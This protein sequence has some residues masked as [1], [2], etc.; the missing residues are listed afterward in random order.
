MWEGFGSWEGC[1]RSSISSPISTASATAMDTVTRCVREFVPRPCSRGGWVDPHI[2]SCK[3]SD[4]HPDNILVSW[5][6]DGIYM[7]NSDQSPEELS[8][9][10]DEQRK[11][12]WDPEKRRERDTADPRPSSSTSHAG[13]DSIDE[14]IPKGL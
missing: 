8:S 13:G 7:F 3:I 5:A 6:G 14:S 12:T 9:G 10:S 1:G 2:T 11:E 4:A